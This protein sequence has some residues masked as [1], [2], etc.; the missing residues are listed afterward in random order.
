MV[1]FKKKKKKKKPVTYAK[2]S[3]KSGEPQRYSLGT[4]KKGGGGGERDMVE[5]TKATLKVVRTRL[6]RVLVYGDG[7]DMLHE[8]QDLQ[9]PLCRAQYQAGGDE[10]DQKNAGTTTSRNGRSCLSPRP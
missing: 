3:P 5:E 7:M 2:I 6:K 4:K 9:T 1:G 8:Q 10:A